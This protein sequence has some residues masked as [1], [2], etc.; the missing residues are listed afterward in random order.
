MRSDE[1]KSRAMRQ[2]LRLVAILAILVIK[3]SGLFGKQ[4]EL[5]ERI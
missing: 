4:K 2:Y 3:P 5:E 1:R